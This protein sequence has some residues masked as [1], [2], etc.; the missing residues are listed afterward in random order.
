MYLDIAAM[1]SGGTP[2]HGG[3]TQTFVRTFLHFISTICK[4]STQD[5]PER[6]H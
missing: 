2:R 6:R 4:D 1:G 5:D 3:T